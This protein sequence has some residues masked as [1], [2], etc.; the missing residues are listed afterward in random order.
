MSDITA[1]TKRVL[2]VL[3][4]QKT[5]ADYVEVEA[6]MP[7][8]KGGYE[9]NINN[10]IH[11]ME[12]ANDN[13]EIAQK[14]LPILLKHKTPKIILDI[15]CYRKLFKFVEAFTILLNNSSE[16]GIFIQLDKYDTLRKDMLINKSPL[17]Y[18]NIQYGTLCGTLRNKSGN[19]V[20]DDLEMLKKLVYWV[21]YLFP[22]KDHYPTFDFPEKLYA[23]CRGVHMDY[24]E[25]Y[26]M[27]YYSHIQEAY[28]YACWSGSMKIV[29]YLDEQIN[30]W[31]INRLIYTHSGIA[32][33]N[34]IKTGEFYKGA[35]VYVGRSGN[36]EMYK[37]FIDGQ[38]TYH[39]EY[40]TIEIA[41][42]ALRRGHI[43]LLN[44]CINDMPIIETYCKDR[45]DSKLLMLIG[46]NWELFDKYGKVNIPQMAQVEIQQ[47]GGNID[48]IHL[49]NNN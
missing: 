5:D 17:E 19:V 20:V 12:I 6:T 1:I 18:Y 14:L 37:H 42:G 43:E 33:S 35:C 48:I 13:P 24:I 15:C 44:A 4:M 7:E 2:E 31:I 40:R 47:E 32:L 10:V 29:K 22:E 30:K 16:M 26:L 9:Q 45:F 41:R 8:L 27:K 46:G 39:R 11:D 34:S 23:I 28:K 25:P 36:V 38:D 49:L 3:Y 21:Y